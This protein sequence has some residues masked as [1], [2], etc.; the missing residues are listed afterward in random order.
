MFPHILVSRKDCLF[1]KGCH[2]KYSTVQ[3]VCHLW[4][5]VVIQSSSL[6]AAYH[7]VLVQKVFKRQQQTK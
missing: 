3:P 2:H 6:M 5:Q 4:K 7:Y 1:H